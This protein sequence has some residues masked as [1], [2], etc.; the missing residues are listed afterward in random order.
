[1]SK[2]MWSP[3]LDQKESNIKIAQVITVAIIAIPAMFFGLL[4]L[5]VGQFLVLFAVGCVVGAVPVVLARRNSVNSI[6]DLVGAREADEVAQARFFNVVDGLS[7]VVGVQKPQLCVVDSAFPIAMAT[8]SIKGD[9]YLVVSTGLGELL[10]RV[11]TEAVI[12]HLLTRLRTTD[13]AIRTFVLSLSTVLSRCGLSAVGRQLSRRYVSAQAILVADSAA[14]QITRYPPALV[15]A[16]E[17]MSKN[18]NLSISEN[19]K[20][21]SLLWFAAFDELVNASKQGDEW[22]T[23]GTHP[24][25]TERIAALKEF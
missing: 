6:L 24:S 25:F 22:S 7:V 21:T 2:Q 3:H 12:A 16:L 10:D 19:K 5:I 13:I 23:I 17:K 18:S 20:L 11:E 1:M 14:C 8:A 4:G 15:S 9:S